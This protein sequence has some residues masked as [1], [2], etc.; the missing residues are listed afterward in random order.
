[1]GAS[2]GLD[3]DALVHHRLEGA[4]AVVRLDDPRRRNVLSRPLSD[5]LAAAVSA[6]LDGGARAL[7]LT[8]APPAFCAGGS[9]DT[10]LEAR[11]ALRASYGG[12]LALAECPVPTVAA[13]DGP[14]VGAG[15]NLALACD[16]VL[17]GPGARFDPRFLDVGIHPGGGHLWRLQ[18]RVGAQGAAALVLMGETLEGE[19]AV[20]AG[21]AWRLVSSDELEEAA[22]TLAGRAAAR[23]AE[24]V[25]RTKASLRA[26]GRIGDPNDAFE[27]ELEAQ[28][29]SVEQPAF[30]EAVQLAR[31]RL[32]SRRSS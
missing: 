20:E 22:V 8:A 23:S 16:V 17:V 9:L 27:L 25:R 15:V 10:L 26:S 7:V 11:H 19:R 14:A 1:M 3:E 6:S 4:V 2:R 30:E 32:V 28:Q 31:A 13:V 24:L 5:Q 21:L 12:Y 18:R 29:W